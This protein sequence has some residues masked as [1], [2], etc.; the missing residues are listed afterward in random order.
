MGWGFG[1]ILYLGID[2]EI[3]DVFIEADSIV[4]KSTDE[5]V[6]QSENFYNDDL[7]EFENLNNSCESIYDLG[8]NQVLIIL[9]DGRNI[10]SW[11]NISEHYFNDIKFISEDF[12]NCSDLSQRYNDVRGKWGDSDYQTVYNL[13]DNVSAMIIRNIDDSITDLSAMFLNCSNLKTLA[14]I[15]TWNT[16][17]VINMNQMFAGC[18]NLKTYWQLEHLDTKN[19]KYMSQM[20]AF[21]KQLENIAFMENWDVSNL[22]NMVGMFQNSNISDLKSFSKLNL[23]KLKN[24]ED[25]FRE[26]EKLTSLKGLEDFNT[27]NVENIAGA[28]FWCTNL[29]DIDALKDWDVSKVENVTLIFSHCK[30]DSLM[31]LKDWDTRNI[32]K[33]YGMFSDCINLTSLKGIESWNTSNVVDMYSMFNG[34]RKITDFEIL[35]KLDTSNVSEMGDLFA[36]CDGLVDLRSIKDLDV[37]NV[38]TMY[39][40]FSGCNNLIS[41]NGIE[42]WDISNVKDLSHAFRGCKNLKDISA[43]RN[44]DIQNVK[45]LFCTFGDNPC[46]TSIEPLKNWNVEN[47]SEV[48]YI[49]E[50]CPNLISL[51]GLENWNLNDSAK[52]DIMFNP[53]NVMK[54][55]PDWYLELSFKEFVERQFPEK[56]LEDPYENIRIHHVL[57]EIR[58]LS[59]NNEK[60]S[61]KELKENI[62]SKRKFSEEKIDSYIE[63]IKENTRY[64]EDPEGYLYEIRIIY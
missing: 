44:W 42:N 11:D 45:K 47:V 49:F 15:E 22:E 26:C 25:L 32:K 17:N 58:V 1:M 19:V 9:K 62:L 59:R 54:D 21:N 63:I 2:E 6:S 30:F 14:G 41:L 5:I 4:K 23:E 50:N 60:V 18:S 8:D 35:T 43:L 20:F 31:P 39:L 34:C 37:S 56:F 64:H 46:L 7:I 28:F 61:I 10:T 3:E 52:K 24:I 55:Y 29:S 40:M 27:K 38:T 16:C 57:D 13:F 51:N 36:N 53:Y 48:Y 33:M 12:S